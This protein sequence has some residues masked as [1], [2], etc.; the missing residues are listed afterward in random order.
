MRVALVALGLVAAA[1]APAVAHPHH[2]HLSGDDER[3]LPTPKKL[4]GHARARGVTL[5]LNATGGRLTG[6]YDDS[7]QN[8]S[9][10]VYG[11]ADHVTVP[12]WKGSQK[13]WAKAVECVKDRLADFDI[14]VVT[15][16]PTSGDYIMIM[17]GGKPGLLGYGSN[18][19]GIA[20]YT[21]EVVRSAI[22]FVFAADNGYDPDYTCVEVLHEAGHTLGLDHEYLCNDPMTYLDACGEQR[23]QDQD[24]PCGEL[25]ERQCE[26]GEDTQNSYR[27]LAANVGL[28]GDRS[29][30]PPN[31]DTG[32]APPGQGDDG[33]GDD[34][35][36][37]PSDNSDD[38]GDDAPAAT[39][40]GPTVTVDD[41]GRHVEGN[42]WIEIDVHASSDRGVADVELGW[43]SQTEQYV[44]D[45]DHIGADQPARCERD[46]DTWRFALYVGTGLRAYA[47]RATDR[48]GNQ[49]VTDPHELYLTEPANDDSASDDSA[50]D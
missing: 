31:D 15:D 9:S 14:D 44:F 48:D 12:A 33:S 18:V 17:V 32:N 27:I 25:N 41:P 28:R 40:P 6:G 3:E 24:A 38:S 39:T 46:G 21:G 5:Y 45:C 10:I 20:P 50:S 30:P 11:V 35:G 4:E 43:A 36:D 34:Q 37:D 13:R 22:G 1:A 26:S 7:S 42:D 2:R 8:V 19:G 16:R 49:T 29:P 23:F 47:V